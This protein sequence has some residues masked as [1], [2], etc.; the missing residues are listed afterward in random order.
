VS[1]LSNHGD[2]SLVPSQ[3]AIVDSRLPTALVELAQLGLDA[4]DAAGCVIAYG[5]GLEQGMVQAPLA[6]PPWVDLEGVIFRM[7]PASLASN[8]GNDFSIIRIEATDFVSNQKHA[9][10]YASRFKLLV[11]RATEDSTW[12]AVGVLLDVRRDETALTAQ[13]KLLS[14]LATAVVTRA[15][16]VA[17]RDFWRERAAAMAADTA[18]A[19]QRLST[20]EGAQ[21]RVEQALQKVLRL[22]PRRRLDGIAETAAE[23]AGCDA[24]IIALANNNTLAVDRYFGLPTVPTL[25]HGSVLAECFRRQT[26]I[27]R[28]SPAKRARV[29]R[30]DGMFAEAGFA[31]YLCAPLYRGAIALAARKSIDLRAR[32]RIEAFVNALAPTAK[33]WALE[34][35]SAN[36]RGL[37]RNLTLRL[38]S[39]GDLERARIS[40]DLHDD[41]AQLLSAARIALSSRRSEATK[42]LAKLEKRL[43]SRLMELR[44]AALGRRSLEQ[45]IEF[46]LR[47]LEAAGIDARFVSPK[48]NPSLARPVE[49]VCYHIVRE[50]VSNIIRHAGAGQVEIGLERTGRSAKLTISDN[51]RGV[52]KKRGGAGLHGLAERVE[53]LG[54]RCS[55]ESKPGRTRLIA[56]IPEIDR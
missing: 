52:G 49:Q 55:L 48:R 20:I 19:R 2:W 11:G 6:P 3:G 39:A 15:A 26:V 23:L 53:F 27:V 35:E 25:D 8:G 4:A 38:I 36:Q 43:R 24:W 47:R 22:E 33:A 14:R 10:I 34:D 45:A 5:D 56:D 37:I 31:A 42:L 18:S 46:E 32:S 13:L 17:S 12:T 54:G 40:R 30:E 51:G 29:Y 50:A 44:P 41:H 21:R 28:E 16:H 7:K 9:P 1:N